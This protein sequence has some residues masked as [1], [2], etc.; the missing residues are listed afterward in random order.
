M[1]KL[2][3]V[4]TVVAAGGSLFLCAAP[5]LA[6]GQSTQPGAAAPATMK[7]GSAPRGKS[8]PPD[9]LEGLTLSDDQKAKIG[10]IRQDT[11]SRL[12]ALNSD[13]NLSPEAADAMR[14]GYQRLE[15]GK[16]LEVLTPEG[17]GGKTAVS[18][19]AGPSIGADSAAAVVHTPSP[20][21]TQIVRERIAQ[22][23]KDMHQAFRQICGSLILAACMAEVAAAAPA[24]LSAA[25]IVTKN[26]AAREKWGQGGISG[27]RFKCRHKRK[28]RW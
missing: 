27:L 14:L 20:L 5:E 24:N 2:A 16:I 8:A 6:L 15:N 1:S 11:K 4:K 26:V 23:N 9:L 21:E 17:R 12:A 3:F 28:P 10:Q 13:K 19:A 22:R 7:P 18:A 25:D